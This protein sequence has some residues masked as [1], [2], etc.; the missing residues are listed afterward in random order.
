MP[1]PGLV[2][3]QVRTRPVRTPRRKA[4]DRRPGGVP[5]IPESGASSPSP[6]RSSSWRNA[7]TVTRNRSISAMPTHT[8]AGSSPFGWLTGRTASAATHLPGTPV[9]P[10][11]HQHS[12]VTMVGRPQRDGF[13]ERPARPYLDS[14]DAHRYRPGRACLNGA[15]LAAPPALPP[16][17]DALIGDGS[18][19]HGRQRRPGTA[20][21]G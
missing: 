21:A 13:S 2:G 15:R 6:N 20:R 14:P 11:L 4:T 1:A 19:G 12:P 17:G 10:V 16:R 7:S 8:P 3:R 5:V 18:A 9:N